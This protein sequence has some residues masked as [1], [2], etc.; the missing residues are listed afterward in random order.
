MDDSSCKIK[1]N[2]DFYGRGIRLGIYLQW[3]SS[4]MSLLVDPQ[5]AQSVFDTNSIFVFAIATATIVAN[6]S[7]DLTITPIEPIDT[8]IMLQF[9]LGFLITTLSTIGIRLNFLRLGGVEE[10]TRSLK[11]CSSETSTRIFHDRQKAT[12]FKQLKKIAS[13]PLNLLLLLKPYHLS[14]SGVLWRT[15]IASIIAWLNLWFWWF[16]LQIPSPSSD[17]NCNSRFSFPFPNPETNATFCRINLWFWFRLQ[18]SSQS[19]DNS[20]DHRFSFPFANPVAFGRIFSIILAAFVFLPALLVLYF[21]IH[22]FYTAF[23]VVGREIFEFTRPKSNA[24]RK[25]DVKEIFNELLGRKKSPLSRISQHLHGILASMPS[26]LGLMDFIGQLSTSDNQNKKVHLTDIFKL[27]VSLEKAKLKRTAVDGKLK[28]SWQRLLPYSLWNIY[29]IIS[30]VWF[31]RCIELTIV[32]NSIEGVDSIQE[33]DP[34]QLIP[35]IIGFV[36]MVQVLKKVV[37]VGLAE[38]YPDWSNVNLVVPESSGSPLGI[39]TD[40]V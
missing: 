16:R 26:S 1:G 21:T 32:N 39:T 33:T 20:C 12:A 3:I 18:T 36:N 11:A 34:G 10:V 13:W 15:A 22:L 6:F 37:L 9:M 24:R 40:R 31:I 27:I 29:I 4:W 35:F 2:P 14:L 25:T 38:I 19:S 28:M 8:F 23:K 7:P 17:I 30:I 5:S